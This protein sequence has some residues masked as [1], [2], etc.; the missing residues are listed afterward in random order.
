MD[1]ARNLS[2]SPGDKWGWVLSVLRHLINALQGAFVIAVVG[3][4]ALIG[5]TA[6]LPESHAGIMAEDDVVVDLSESIDNHDVYLSNGRGRRRSHGSN[7][8]GTGNS[9]PKTGMSV[10]RK[11]PAYLVNQ[12]HFNNLRIMSRLVFGQL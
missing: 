8:D 3:V 1:N 9:G 6:L 12:I 5:A 7:R 11:N 4:V 10:R 2:L